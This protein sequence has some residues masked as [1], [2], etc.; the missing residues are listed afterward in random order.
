MIDDLVIVFVFKE[1]KII[2]SFRILVKKKKCIRLKM[3]LH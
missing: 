2:S 1:I 3:G